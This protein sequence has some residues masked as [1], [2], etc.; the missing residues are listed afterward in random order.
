MSMLNN[1]TR[2]PIARP[3]Y[4]GLYGPGGVGKSTF[5]AA[6]P[7]P[8]FIGTDDGTGTMDVARFPLLETWSNAIA[9]IDTLEKEKHDFE[10]AVIDTVNGLEPLLWAHLCREARCNSIEEIDGG[11]G[12]G[13]VR[14]TE[15]WVEYFKRLKRLRN[16]MNV[17]TLGHAIVKTVEDVIEGER[18][19]R[20][21]LKMHQQAAAAWHESVDCMFFAKFDQ[22]FRKEKGARKARATGEGKRIMFTEERPGFLAKSRFDLPTEMELSWDDFAARAAVAKAHASQDD[23]AKVFA[24]IEEDALAFLIHNG[25]LVEGQA[26]ADLKEAKRKPILNKADDFRKAVKDFAEKKNQP[27]PEPTTT[28]E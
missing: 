19:D 3:H 27:E 22:S 13:Y 17:I 4:I 26:L 6:A 28:D 9:A 21:L 23:L 25:W 7:R 11:F 8:I 12:K 14:A 18:Y 16:K 24:G 10:T 2:G 20:Y 1:I 5:A 15:Q